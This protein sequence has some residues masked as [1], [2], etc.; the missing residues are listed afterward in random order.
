M[1]DVTDILAVERYSFSFAS[2]ESSQVS[3]PSA[4]AF[5]PGITTGSTLI[6]KPSNSPYSLGAYSLKA[7]DIMEETKL[8]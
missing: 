2:T 8:F 1:A 4:Y 7:Y 5:T 3:S 6:F